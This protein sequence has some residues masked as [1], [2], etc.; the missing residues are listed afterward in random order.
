MFAW[1]DAQI[2]KRR[3]IGRGKTGLLTI[4]KVFQY[5]LVGQGKLY[6]TDVSPTY[7]NCNKNERQQVDLEK[8]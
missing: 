8:N 1:G 5:L 6:F 7:D 2:T 4:G 3:F